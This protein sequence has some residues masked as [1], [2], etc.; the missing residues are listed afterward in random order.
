[1]SFFGKVF[2][3]VFNEVRRLP[4]FPSHHLSVRGLDSAKWPPRHGALVDVPEIAPCRNDS[5]L[6]LCAGTGPRLGEQQ[7]IPALCRTV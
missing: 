1:M 6:A 4:R 3:Y 2:S 5:C 7:D